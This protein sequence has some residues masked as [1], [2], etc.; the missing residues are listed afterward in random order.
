MKES[1]GAE[2]EDD[3]DSDD[4][5]RRIASQELKASPIKAPAG[6]G[7]VDGFGKSRN[8]HVTFDV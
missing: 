2:Y 4:S 3:F 7:S 1:K 5:V 6:L 8:S